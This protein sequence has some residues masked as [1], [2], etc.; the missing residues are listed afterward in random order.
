MRVQLGIQDGS[1]ATDAVTKQQLDAGIADA[2]AR[3]SH[4]GTQTS[5]TISDFQAAVDARVQQI[6]GASPAALDT[7]VELAAAL[8]ND[9][10]YAATI[11]GQIT[12]INGRLTAL[13][14]A[15]TAKRTASFLVGNG[16]A[17][18]FNVDH[19]WNLADKNKVIVQIRDAGTGE[20][21]DASDVATTANRVVVDFGTHVPTSNQ[22]RVL[23][24]EI[25]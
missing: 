1:A 11:A 6:V 25:A 15:G 10:N 7:L 2:K 3:G 4:T 12:T 19:N 17:S 13:E 9:A 22:Y 5:A 18:S 23:V 21:V 20:S 24:Q 8:G 14:G 16:A